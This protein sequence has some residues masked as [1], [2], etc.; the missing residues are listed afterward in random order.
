MSSSKK[1]NIKILRG[2]LGS[3]TGSNEKLIITKKGVIYLKTYK[4]KKK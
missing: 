3:P 2:L 4:S 1:K